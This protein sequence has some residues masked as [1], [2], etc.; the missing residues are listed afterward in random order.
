MSFPVKVSKLKEQRV[1]IIQTLL[2]V[3]VLLIV[4]GVNEE[5]EL[6]LSLGIVD[7]FV[8]VDRLYADFDYGRKRVGGVKDVL[9][10]YEK[11]PKKKVC[12]CV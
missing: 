3:P 2:F 7:W 11:L 9:L 5:L 12:A 4:Y 8:M 10:L 6:L 1:L